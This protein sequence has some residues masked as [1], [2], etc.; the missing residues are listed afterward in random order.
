MSPEDIFEMFFGG[1][2][3]RGSVNQRRRTNFFTHTQTRDDNAHREETV[4][5]LNRKL[6]FL[7]CYFFGFKKTY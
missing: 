1:G 4:I 3:G 7:K 5:N 2:F 6:I